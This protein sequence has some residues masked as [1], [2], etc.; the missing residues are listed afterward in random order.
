MINKEENSGRKDIKEDY[1][2]AYEPK[3][4]EK[5]K[6]EI[7]IISKENIVFNLSIVQEKENILF[8]ATKKEDIIE[9]IYKKNVTLSDF[10]TQNK[11][12]NKYDNNEELFA[13]IM[14]L[15]INEID[16]SFIENT[17]TITIAIKFRKEIIK[18]NILLNAEE[19]KTDN[20]KN[21]LCQ[22]EK[23]NEIDE[24]EISCDINFTKRKKIFIKYIEDKS[25]FGIF[26]DFNDR[27]VNNNL[28]V[29]KFNN[30]DTY[31]FMDDT[32][33]DNHNK[34]E[35][36]LNEKTNIKKYFFDKNDFHN[37]NTNEERPCFI[38]G[39]I[40]EKND[41]GKYIIIISNSVS[42]VIFIRDNHN[43]FEKI[44]E[45]DF[46]YFSFL[47]IEKQ[48]KDIIYLKT[49]KF[50]QINSDLENINNDKINEK[51]LIKLTSIQLKKGSN[52][53]YNTF[54]LYKGKNEVL[55]KNIDNDKIYFIYE[56]N[57][58]SQEYIPL[59]YKL[60]NEEVSSPVF[61]SFFSKGYCNE[62]NILLNNKK[63][64]VYEYLFYANKN[65][66]IPKSIT[67]RLSDEKD[68]IFSNMWGYETKERKKITF[69]NI[70]LQEGLN[71]E[72]M[73]S[74]L[75]IF[76]CTK[77]NEI[78]EYGTFLLDKLEL[79]IK[80]EV[81]INKDF[82]NLL[83][84]INQDIK[85]FLKETTVSNINILKTKYLANNNVRK[86]I[87]ELKS[88]YR[89]FFFPEKKEMFDYYNN[90]CIWNILAKSNTDE[91]SY[92]LENYLIIYDNI[93]H[94]NYNISDKI[95]LL[96]T[97]VRGIFEENKKIF[98]N[99]IFFDELEEEYNSYTKAYYFHLKLIDSLKDNSILIKPFLQLGSYIME[100]ILTD[101]EKRRIKDLE[102]IV[103]NNNI[104]DEN[105][106]KEQIEK[107]QN[108]KIITKLAY[109]ISM[110][111]VDTIKKH[112]K[113]TMKPYALIYGLNSER[114][115]LAVV[116]KDNNIITFNEDEIFKGAYNYQLYKSLSKENK[117]NYAFILNM[118]FLHENSS[119]NK[120]KVI[121]TKINSPVIFLDE[122]FNV[123]FNII[124]FNINAGEAG[125]FTERFIGDREIILGL[126]NYSNKLGDL[127][128]VKYFNKE[129]FKDLIE[130][131]NCLKEK[132]NN[133]D[134]VITEYEA[135]KDE[136]IKKKI[137]SKEKNP[138]FAK[139]DSSGFN[140]FDRKLFRL[141]ILKNEDY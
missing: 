48:E 132:D 139:V 42:K 140:E 68:Y 3:E 62:L 88:D 1:M 71:L 53:I 103:A 104:N 15:E 123:A 116:K 106:R 52:N 129:N 120:E 21:K 69:V 61:S 28:K 37:F 19:I 33:K 13:L 114:N 5:N 77:I 83:Q 51:I 100:K 135:Y 2:K 35:I 119:H 96:I 108:E 91:W 10:Q 78:R 75:K 56:E 93:I 65:K 55:K 105:K 122:N 60:C 89:G 131:Y 50:T 85:F 107:I 9:K 29:Y 111:S 102:I 97:I 130:E 70:P 40:F 7:E 67:I 137:K 72:G 54:K 34:N 20:N 6:R 41:E 79:K 133:N 14:D 87:N 136:Y 76:I 46:H 57:D 128:D 84:N 124:D 110:T 59:K 138:R 66:N 31:Y 82:Q 58:Y 22:K 49:T 30:G 36:T 25:N 98:P 95:Y 23:I 24:G 99:I 12:F 18:T 63:G 80:E 134:E 8:K 32:N 118:L 27:K 38:Y 115:Y 64:F 117:N 47:K 73:Y 101:D 125:H 94:K 44:K 17:V 74:Y 86:Y 112:L 16:L 43:I 109:T 81:T 90:I 45:N 92:L 113:A 26:L 141:S 4:E 39:K 121:N 127:L 126:L 11:L